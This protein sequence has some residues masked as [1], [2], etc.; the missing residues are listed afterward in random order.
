[1]FKQN[2]T[3]KKSIKVRFKDDLTINSYW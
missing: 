1:M 3:N 2:E